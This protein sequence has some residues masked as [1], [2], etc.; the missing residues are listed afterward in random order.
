MREINLDRLFAEFEATAAPTFRPPGVDAARRRVNRR[1]RRRRGLLAGLVALLL[2]GPGVYATAGRDADRD[3]PD[4]TPSPATPSPAPD[5]QVI[6]RKVNPVGVAGR[7]A[8]LR[9]VDARHGWALFDTCGPDDSDRTGCRLDLART[10]DGGATWQRTPLPDTANNPRW[11]G[12]YYLLPLDGRNLTVG[13]PDGYLVTTD[14]GASFTEHP[15]ESPPE[16][17]RLAAATRRGYLLQCPGS[18]ALIKLNCAEWELARIGAAKVPTQPPVILSGAASNDLIDG[19]D[20]RIWVTTRNGDWLTV[21]VSD[22]DGGTWQELPD[23]AGAARLLVSPDGR[24]AWLVNI[25]EGFDAP[26]HK[27]VWRLDG[28]RWQE[29]TQL[30]P[31][32]N[33][34]AAVNGGLLA[35]T[36]PWGN[37]GYWTGDRYLDVPVLRRRLTSGEHPPTVQVLP[38]DTIVITTPTDTTLGT[39]PAQT[40]TWTRHLH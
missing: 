31:D 20:G 27:R 22:D 5:G 11:A 34:A 10:A 40:R 7:L 32:T 24:D 13:V 2:T 16:V 28:D 25:N 3:P 6:E 12:P 26:T 30:P 37:V 33:S 15:R 23:V 4:P 21:A 36:N 39:G 38:D 14:G 18:G 9:F 8:G 1:R 35:V 19:G 29:R 17:T